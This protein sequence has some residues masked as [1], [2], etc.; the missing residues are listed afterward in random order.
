MVS[1]K[2]WKQKE[3]SPI[4]LYRHILNRVEKNPS[5]THV[6]RIATCIPQ[7]PKATIYST[8]I[9]AKKHINITWSYVTTSKIWIRKK[10]AVKAFPGGLN[11]KRRGVLF[12]QRIW[13]TN[14]PGNCMHASGQAL[15]IKTLLLDTNWTCNQLLDT[16]CCCTSMAR[17]NYTWFILVTQSSR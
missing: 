11:W 17:G 3:S 1:R 14:N 9:G 15:T 2:Q 4:H 10:A 13:W 7:G 6:L 5:C 12:R 16:N 8:C